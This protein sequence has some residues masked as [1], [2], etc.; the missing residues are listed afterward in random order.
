M[1]L[2]SWKEKFYPILASN[3][4]KEEA[5]EHSLNKWRGLR[6][7]D[8]FNLIWDDG[9]ISDGE[10]KLVIDITSCALC[11][12]YIEKEDHTDHECEKC[13]LY[14]IRDCACDEFF[15]NDQMSPYT[16]WKYY[17]DPERMI[18]LIERAKNEL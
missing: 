17:G 5:I 15:F 14:K 8:E 12:H 2:K 10:E 11:Y 7:L 9:Y 3:C 18:S 6:K 4:P 1:S 13:P 16:A